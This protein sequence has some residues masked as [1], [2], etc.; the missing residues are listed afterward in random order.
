M[1]GGTDTCTSGFIYLDEKEIGGFSEKE[2]TQY[3]RY[4]ATAKN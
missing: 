2:S 4:A 1:P 3:R